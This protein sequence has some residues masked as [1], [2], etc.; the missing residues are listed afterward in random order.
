[1]TRSQRTYL[2]LGLLAVAITA[3]ALW[4]V[5][6]GWLSVS[7]MAAQ[8]A[9][10]RT[11]PNHA[12]AMVAFVLANGIATAVGLPGLEFTI[13]AGAVYGVVLG[14]V[15]ACAGSLVGALGGY[16]IARFAGKDLVRRRL[17]RWKGFDEVETQLTTFAGLFRLRLLPFV[18]L[19]IVNFGA[20]LVRSPLGVYVVTT[21]VGL[22]PS[23]AVYCYFADAVLERAAGAQATAT[24]HVIVASVLLIL[25][26]LVPTV[27]KRM[28]ARR[29]VA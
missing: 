23:T 11:A 2:L 13:V 4:A 25:M 6:A 18:P 10:L 8:A 26:S 1:M 3:G 20:G 21:V 22:A 15:V 12:G 29:A 19:S 7:H 28:Q 5:H 24:R 9:K 17:C 27:V 14:T 16:A